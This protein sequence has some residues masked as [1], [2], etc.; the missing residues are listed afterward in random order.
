MGA[1]DVSEGGFPVGNGG[2]VLGMRSFRVGVVSGRPTGTTR[3]TLSNPGTGAGC[4]VVGQVDG[5]GATPEAR[6]SLGGSDERDTTG[7]GGGW[8]ARGG[9]EA[10]GCE[11]AEG[12]WG[13]GTGGDAWDDSGTCAAEE[14][15]AGVSG[16]FPRMSTVVFR[17]RPFFG[18][19]PVGRTERPRRAGVSDNGSGDTLSCLAPAPGKG[20]GPDDRR[21]SL[22]LT[23][24]PRFS[25]VS[26][27]D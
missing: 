15:C 3:E 5:A 13:D 8:E 17:V 20:G 9:T 21:S 25:A 12:C 23:N 4:R 14:P 7:G 6:G 19:I 24:L 16:R 27:T 18:T 1:A 22:I 11:G 26:R 10:R 2:G